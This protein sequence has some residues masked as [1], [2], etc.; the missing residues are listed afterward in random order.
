VLNSVACAFASKS[1]SALRRVTS[2]AETTRSQVGSFAPACIR[3]P[4]D[5][6]NLLFS[7]QERL[8]SSDEDGFAVVVPA[9]REGAFVFKT[10]NTT[11]AG[12][13]AKAA[14]YSVKPLMLVAGDDARRKPQRDGTRR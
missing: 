11:G 3:A 14:D 8:I 7:R 2:M 9:T 12:N 4:V 10:L 1:T 13:M 6:C 5:K